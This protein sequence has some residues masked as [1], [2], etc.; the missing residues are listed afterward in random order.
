MPL[1]VRN[2]Y[3]KLWKI[4]GDLA[5]LFGTNG[6]PTLVLLF[7]YLLGEFWWIILQQKTR[8]S[9]LELTSCMSEILT[10]E[11]VMITTWSC[12]SIF[13]HTSV[14]QANRTNLTKWKKSS[15]LPSHSVISQLTPK[16]LLKCCTEGMGGQRIP[17][18]FFEIGHGSNKTTTHKDQTGWCSVCNPRLWKAAPTWSLYSGWSGRA[19]TDSVLPTEICRNYPNISVIVSVYPCIFILHFIPKMDLSPCCPMSLHPVLIG[20]SF[21][22]I[23]L[24]V[25]A[26]GAWTTLKSCSTWQ[27]LGNYETL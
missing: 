19:N 10:V 23:C 7:Y 14:S 22:R 21:R 13:D 5:A 6:T 16:N 18:A 17:A 24:V 27:P 9:T 12:L 4:V 20:R 11:T 3:G 26:D 1:G 2:W 25:P 15:S 8:L